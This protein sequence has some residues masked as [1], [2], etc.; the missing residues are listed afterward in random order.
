ME[1][2][3]LLYAHPSTA[4]AFRF[5]FGEPRRWAPG[6]RID[7]ATKLRRIVEHF[8]SVG[9]DVLY[10]D[11]TPSDMASLGVFTSR[12]VVPGFQPIWFGRGERRLGGRRMFEFAFRQGL[13]K[14]VTEPGDLNPMPHPIA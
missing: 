9:Q 14:A 3:A 10:V 11:L 1:D 13:R 12:V 5:L 7:S 6:P 2:H 8:R 4:W